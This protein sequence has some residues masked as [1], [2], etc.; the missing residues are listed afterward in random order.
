MWEIR[1]NQLFLK[2]VD[3]V[4]HRK[5][6]FFWKKLARYNLK[7]LFPKA[8]NRLVKATWYSG[9]LRIP[10]GK[11]TLYDDDYRSCFEQEVIVTIE[12]GV[13]KRMVTLDNMKRRLTVNP[14]A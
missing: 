13:I 12:K 14:I 8:K 7:I 6:L 1:G 2:A 4:Y 10:Q 11:M 5:A 9:R 3:G